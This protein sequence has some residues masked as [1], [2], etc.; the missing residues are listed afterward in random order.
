MRRRTIL[1]ALMAAAA[2]SASAQG[3]TAEVQDARY[4][5]SERGGQIQFTGKTTEF[6]DGTIMTLQLY[7][8]RESFDWT[9][10]AIS[11]IV[12]DNS[13]SMGREAVRV[14]K[15]S[16]TADA[17][18]PGTYSLQVL[19]DPRIQNDPEVA[20]FMGREN[21][22]YRFNI[23]LYAADALTT[24]RQ[25]KKDLGELVRLSKDL[26]DLS[27]Q[28]ASQMESKER[29]E[30][31][32]EAMVLRADQWRAAA[33][34][35]AERSI[36]TGTF[37]AYAAL[38]AGF[39][40]LTQFPLTEAEAAGD[41][42]G[43]IHTAVF[44]P[45]GTILS[46]T[47]IPGILS[48]IE[49]FL[50]RELGLVLFQYLSANTSPLGVEVQAAADDPKLETQLRRRLQ[51]LTEHGPEL[52]ALYQELAK[53]ERGEAFVKASTVYERNGEREVYSLGRAIEEFLTLVKAAEATLDGKVKMEE[54]TEQCGSIPATFKM[55]ES[56][57]RLGGDPAPPK[58]D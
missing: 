55:L 47:R 6:P 3:F 27:T 44:S 16:W 38:G 57:L 4:S 11:P 24:A 56:K 28:L 10:A 30:R 19:Y 58:P 32:K 13:L 51:T 21:V 25:I 7:L 5:R 39:R 29:Y 26:D 49:P 15:F 33:R 36:L 48:R 50:V 40:D 41:A 37:D 35:G 22:P 53:S 42:G 54:F 31:T 14:G 34:V 45:D 20:R 52:Q 43:R 12:S 8:Q 46:P 17:A 23:P 9:S 1:A 18:G 2:S